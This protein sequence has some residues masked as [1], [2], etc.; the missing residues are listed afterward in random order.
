[1]LKRFPNFTLI[2]ATLETGRTHQ[3]RVHMSTIHHPIAGDPV[4]GKT[5]IPSALPPKI[6]SILK[7]LKRQA[8]HAETLDIIH[9]E[10]GRYMEFT[11][12]LPDDMKELLNALEEG[13]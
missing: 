12:P 3:I 13:C 6:I 9:P 8:L 7:R 1:V 2:E 5:S 10:T 4:Y 11:S